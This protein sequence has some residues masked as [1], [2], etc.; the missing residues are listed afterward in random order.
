MLLESLYLLKAI[1]GATYDA[2]VSGRTPVRAARFW[3]R[4]LTIPCA[5]TTVGTMSI[6]KNVTKAQA[7]GNDFV[8]YVDEDGQYDPTAREVEDICDRHFGIG[9]DGVIR[10][11]HPQYVRDL[12]AEQVEAL[13]QEGAEWFMD[14]RNADGSLAQM[15]GNGTRATTRFAMDQ[16]LVTLKDGEEFALGT[17]SGVKRIASL[18][19]VQGLGE[20]VF[21]VNMGA[22]KIG[23]LDQYTVTVNHASGKAQGTFVD[24]GNPHVVAVIEDAYSSLP[25]L[26]DLDLTQPPM[27][28]PEID[29]GQNVEF[30]RIDEIDS[31]EDH[32]EASMRVFERGCGETLSCGTG[33]CATAIVLRAKTGVDHWNVTVKGGTLRIDVTDNTV[34]LTGDAQLVA[35]VAMR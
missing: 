13:Q 23:E 2:H 31:R 29:E 21:R 5:I 18:G 17:R 19:Q 34:L 16:K 8:L 6:P 35:D 15:C 14:Y 24:M 25:V 9:A 26:A 30:V 11:T 33:L 27:V 4:A 12:S 32:G 28:D 1:V 22:W 7:T 3:D 10:V 20:H